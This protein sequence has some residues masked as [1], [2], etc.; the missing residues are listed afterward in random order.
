MRTLK[1]MLSMDVEVPRTE[2]GASGPENWDASHRYIRGYN[3]LAHDAGF[4]ITYFIHPEAAMAHRDL[5]EELHKTQG[6]SIEGLHVHP[7]KFMDGRFK[8]HF[9]GM[10]AKLQ[11]DVLLLAMNMWE[12][13]FG[14]L[15]RYFRPG[16]FSANDATFAILC[17]LGFLGGSLSA[18]ERFFPDLQA[19]WTG[20]PRDPHRP[21]AAFRNIKG[22]LPF[23]NVPHSHD[24]TTLIET[25]GRHAYADLRPCRDDGDMKT[26]VR[27][28]MTQ[29]LER[30]AKLPLITMDTHNDN[31]YTDAGNSVCKR[32][33][34]LLDSLH[35]VAGE[36]NVKLEGTTIEQ[37]TQ[38]VMSWPVEDK[39]FVYA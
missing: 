6:A 4:P 7:W 18:P 29:T 23:A 32:Y 38:D 11:R 14:R 28:I 20:A 16:T 5:F 27:N 15:P 34:S 22:T 26:L 8:Y 39:P 21:N 1:I 2:A 33:Q 35:E 13:A 3:Q 9:G 30:N 25:P 10:D 36:L 19:I 24:Y 17:D 12:E 31:D 37:A